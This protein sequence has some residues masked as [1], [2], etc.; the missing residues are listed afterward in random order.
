[1][2]IVLGMGNFGI[3]TGNIIQNAGNITG[4][5]VTENSQISNLAGAVIGSIDSFDQVHI[6]NDSDAKINGKVTIGN[7]GSVDN[8]GLINNSI[9]SGS[10]NNIH[11]KSGGIINGNIITNTNSKVI[12]DNNASISGLVFIKGNNA[13]FDNNGIVGAAHITD[14]AT[15]TNNNLIIGNNVVSLNEKSTLTN[16]GDIYIGYTYD[17]ST[18]T[19]T[20]ASSNKDAYTAIDITGIDAKLFNNKT[21][22]VSSSQHDI[23]VVSIKNGSEYVDT[24]NSNIILNQE[25]NSIQK[26]DK[27]K[28]NNNTIIYVAGGNSATNI[29]GTLTLNDIGSSALWVQDQGQL[30]LSGTVKLNS[31][32]ITNASGN[33]DKNTQI[34]S[35]GA[36]I[37][38]NGSKFTMKDNAQILL[39]ADRAIGVHIRDGAMAEINDHPLIKF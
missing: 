29:K 18:N 21:I 22:H 28:G 32:N 5:I 35:F 19:K 6:T 20:S 14:G 24:I 11:N 15:S 38:G 2:V 16:N 9:N 7:N 33:L 23:K 10:G 31:K 13:T 26:V 8:A 12:N 30:T 3:S 25:D 4:K 27:D 39:N 36:W 17:N 1:M 34:R 37:E